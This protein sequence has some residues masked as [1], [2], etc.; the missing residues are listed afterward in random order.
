M[1]DTLTQY[2]E[3]VN[4]YIKEVE[5]FIETH[6]LVAL[7]PF[8]EYRDKQVWGY[9]YSK[10]Q[11]Y[12]E[13]VSMF[14]ANLFGIEAFINKDKAETPQRLHQ[15]YDLLLKQITSELRRLETLLFRAKQRIDFYQS[16]AHVVSNFS[17]GEY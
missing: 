10:D 9:D 13:Q 3:I 2:K 6:D 1:S 8:D 4:S 7:R 11:I 14:R 16:L 15:N 17:Y 12:Y 5:E